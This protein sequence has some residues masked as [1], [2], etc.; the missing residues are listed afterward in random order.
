[1]HRVAQTYGEVAVESLE[2]YF[3]NG[4][5]KLNS[6]RYP[7]GQTTHLQVTTRLPALTIRNTATGERQ[8]HVVTNNPNAGLGKACRKR[9]R[10]CLERKGLAKKQK[11][12]NIDPVQRRADQQ[13]KT[14]LATVQASQI[15]TPGQA[16]QRALQTI[17]HADNQYNR[18]KKPQGRQK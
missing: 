12:A 5:E 16:I 8:K 1:M 17:D 13:A 2:Q 3:R 6:G 11:I 9:K 4:L 7:N 15:Q 10:S 14:L 18:A